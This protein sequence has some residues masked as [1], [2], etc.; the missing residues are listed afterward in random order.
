MNERREGDDREYLQGGEDIHESDL[1]FQKNVR[2]VYLWQVRENIDFDEI[3]CE[4]KNNSMLS[5]VE[6][7]KKIEMK[8]NKVLNI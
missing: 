7:F 6:I 4:G 8:I 3:D 1:I 2:D 5:P